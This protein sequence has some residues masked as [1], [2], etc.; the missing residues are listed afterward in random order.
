MALITTFFLGIFIMAG[1]LIA[2]SAK[3]GRLIGQLSV[4]IAFGTMSALAVLD[5]LP[6]AI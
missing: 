4:S 1:A 5:L 6:E 2:R 3:N